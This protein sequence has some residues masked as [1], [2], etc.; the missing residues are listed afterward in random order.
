MDIGGAIQALKAG[1][2]VAREGWYGLG[3][4]I[5]LSGPIEG[6]RLS[7]ESFWS[8]RNAEYAE[9]TIDKCALVLPCITL[10]NAEGQIQMGWLAS[11]PDLLAEDWFLIESAG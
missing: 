3:M 11:Q 5:A 2:R 8:K 9:Q 7:A 1:H 10:K 6:R 4:W